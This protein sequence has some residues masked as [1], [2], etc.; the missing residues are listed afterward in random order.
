[1]FN[2][3]FSFL[4]SKYPSLA[5]LGSQAESYVD[6]DAN[7][8]L[9]KSGMLCENIVK[10]LCAY[11]RIKPRGDRQ[12]T[13]ASRIKILQREGV[14]QKDQCLV[15]HSIRNARNKA[16]HED[17]ASQ[18]SANIVLM[19]IHR[20]ASWFMLSYGGV[21]SIPE[22]IKPSSL[23]SQSHNINTYT[24]STNDKVN[25]QYEQTS[26]CITR[27]SKSNDV[28]KTKGSTNSKENIDKS[29]KNEDELFAKELKK[30]AHEDLGS[31]SDL[32]KRSQGIYNMQELSEIETRLIIDEQ[33]RAVG[34]EADS[35]TLRYSKGV[36]PKSGCNMAIAEWPT[37]STDN[38][39]RTCSA[40]YALFIGTKLFAFIEAK[41]A[42]KDVSAVL[43]AQGREYSSHVRDEDK[44]YIIDTY[45]EYQ[46]PFVFATN[47]RFYVEQYKQKSG[48]WF[49]DLRRTNSA[50]CALHGFLSP[51]GLEELL[52]QKVEK[53]FARLKEEPY[54]ILESKSGLNLR[55]YQIDAI[56]AAE[57]AIVNGQKRVLLAMATGTGKTRTILGFI[58]RMLKTKSFKRI[59][60]IVDRTSL[61]DQT[62][63]VF[64][65]VELEDY[66]TLDNIYSIK[67]LQDIKIEK[68]TKVQIATVQSLV[69]R[70]I[71]ARNSD[72]TEYSMPGV[73]DYDLVVVD[74]AHRGYILDK[75]MTSDE[76]LFTDQR[77]F[78]SKYRTVI[79]YFDAVKVA[80]TATPALHT[81]QIF[82]EPVYSYSYRQAVIDGYL[83]DYNPP[84]LLK[85]E[86]N[87]HGIK[88]K[89]GESIEFYD[90]DTGTVTTKV[91]EDELNFKVDDFNR[92]VIVESF[93]R[94]FLAEIADEIDP[95]FCDEYGK[96]LIYAVND[97]HADMIVS[98]LK[99][100]YAPRGVSDMVIK[101][102][103]KT[104]DGNQK[105]IQEL[106]R[107]FKNER[108]PGIVVTVDL[109]TT[110]IDVPS[111][112]KLVF[113]RRV[114]SRILYEQM[115]GRATR[116][117]QNINKDHFDIY[118]AVNVTSSF[119]AY[120]EM[121]P[122]AAKQ[123]QTFEELVLAILNSSNHNEIEFNVDRL[124]AKMHRKN[125]SMDDKAQDTFKKLNNDVD[126][127]DFIESLSEK[128]K[129]LET[130][131]DFIKEHKDLIIKLDSLKSKTESLIA[132]SEKQDL[133]IS[134]SIS[135]GGSDIR[136]EDYI[137][138]LRR[139]LQENKDKLDIIQS[140]CTRPSDLKSSDLK[141]LLAELESDNYTMMHINKALSDIHRNDADISCDIIT[142]IRGLLLDEPLVSHKDKVERA[143]AELYK[144]HEFTKSQKAWLERFKQY[145]LNDHTAVLSVA[146][147]DEDSRFK[148]LGGF[149]LIDR[150]FEQ[151]L[152]IYINEINDL[153]LTVNEQ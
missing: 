13:F 126:L 133:F 18:E 131:Y 110:G 60:Y 68:S 96:T 93:N 57:S 21:Q 41:S 50:P 34:F 80:L 143:F 44:E 119:D 43:D 14:L 82:G 63:D 125:Q 73:N 54:S 145:L 74:E 97:A 144:R 39:G 129:D 146:T 101:L 86:F 135:Y 132:I 71:Y 78:I 92:K 124:L 118:D 20:V 109:L 138:G 32:K 81:V 148:S 16:A 139:Y 147:M 5:I 121:K 58:Y 105:R 24:C 1:M 115:L 37:K 62:I 28:A 79:D 53:T 99:E 19:L 107:K 29:V 22:F 65:D 10:L 112:T 69:K 9:I 52:E 140:I 108:S 104:A 70:I 56:K 72:D 142:I 4:Q 47:G 98:I 87:Q 136:P 15:L 76:A 150:T 40:D 31:L 7:A 106:I 77:D 2:S 25:L 85:T 95:T 122:V 88:Y 17:L 6:S 111:I 128:R 123:K 141:K 42:K 35:N 45:G 26:N 116:K 49:Q 36:R 30:A 90:N 137:E 8:S 51:Q 149:T 120:T 48:V 83:V 75:E 3:N 59:L 94:S 130:V 151:E 66:L 61:G 89:A 152:N 11:H 38:H 117:C 46:V 91:L 27:K 114:K 153:L 23:V 84:V 55:K 12:D 64:K 113:V 103:G 33:L 127:T 100:I 134:K 67:A 102:T